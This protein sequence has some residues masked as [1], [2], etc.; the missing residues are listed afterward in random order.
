MILSRDTIQRQAE[1]AAEQ[2]LGPQAN[3]YPEGSEFSDE[4]LQYYY[5]RVLELSVE[6]VA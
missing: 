5:A 1:L 2:E 6:C 4:W 3:P